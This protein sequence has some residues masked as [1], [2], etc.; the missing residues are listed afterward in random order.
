[1]KKWLWFPIGILA[2]IVILGFMFFASLAS[3][4][5][6][7]AMLYVDEG[8]VEVDSGK[9]WI[10][11]QDGMELSIND[12]VRTLEGKATIV[13][14]EGEMTR[15]EPNTE[16]SIKELSLESTTISQNSG[17]T[18]NR[19]TKL[20]GVAEYNVETPTTVATVRGTG[21]G[22]RSSDEGVDVLVGQGKVEVGV[23]DGGRLLEKFDVIENQK[24]RAAA[25]KLSKLS[26][27]EKDRAMLKEHLGRDIE[28]LKKIRR[29]EI[30]KHKFA[31]EVLKRTNR[32]SDADIEKGLD[33]LDKGQLNEDELEQKA[34]IKLKALKRIV[35][36]T[37]EIKNLR[38]LQ[39]NQES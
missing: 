15:L 5:V 39:E 27:S 24:V 26:L 6:I 33:D 23:Y 30:K 7:G 8:A 10:A 13:I 18:W 17:S 2:L 36:M 38:A 20:G 25:K 21:F 1:M 28:T 11:A 19:I 31:L 16:V 32:L 22:L 3:G 4:K 14:F 9:G 35:A 37:K 34:P 12:K 29:A